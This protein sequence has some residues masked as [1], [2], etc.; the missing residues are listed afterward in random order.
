VKLQKTVSREVEGKEYYKWLII[1]PPENIEKLHW[2]DGE[3]LESKVKDD[4][5]IIRLMTEKSKKND[6]M[7]YDDFK[8]IVK[9][10]LEKEPKGL[11]WTQIREKRPELYQ[12]VPNN[13]WVYT[14]ERDV[15]LLKKK[16]GTKTLWRLK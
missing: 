12:K 3:E 6:K 13:L 15:G 5:L 11:T 8:K 16:V 10:E 2:K 7:T 4:D 1:I 9:E 14:L